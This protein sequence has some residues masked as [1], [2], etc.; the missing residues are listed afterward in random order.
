MLGMYVQLWHAG[1]SCSTLLLGLGLTPTQLA[2][3]VVQPVCHE[4]VPCPPL[5]TWGLCCSRIYVI[6]E[7]QLLAEAKKRDN[8]KAKGERH[9]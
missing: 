5:L 9:A 1:R 2:Q 4:K 8:I 7:L 6:K 3:R